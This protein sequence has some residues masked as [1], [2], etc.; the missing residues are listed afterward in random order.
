M[1][2]LGRGTRPLRRQR[3]STHVDRWYRGGC[4]FYRGCKFTDESAPFSTQAVEDR[5]CRITPDGKVEDGGMEINIERKGVEWTHVK[6]DGGMQMG[7]IVSCSTRTIRPMHRHRP[8]MSHAPTSHHQSNPS[9]TLPSQ[10]LLVPR[11]DAVAHP[12]TRNEDEEM[13]IYLLTVDE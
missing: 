3:D 12:R 5:L 10:L 1:V 8:P 6:M 11:V 4:D 7:L 9:T 2:K 13:S